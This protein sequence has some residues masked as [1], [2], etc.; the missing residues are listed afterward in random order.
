MKFPL[1]VTFFLSVALVWLLV[2]IALVSKTP[3]K[4]SQFS[5]FSHYYT[6]LIEKNDFVYTG[7]DRDQ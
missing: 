2:D 1:A 5:S 3:P 6:P 4:F 7:D